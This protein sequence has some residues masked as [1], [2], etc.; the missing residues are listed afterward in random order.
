MVLVES[1]RYPRNNKKCGQN[2]FINS[3]NFLQIKIS[4]CSQIHTLYHAIPNCDLYS[5]N[6]KKVIFGLGPQCIFIRT[7]DRLEMRILYGCSVS[8]EL[9]GMF[10]VKAF[11]T[12]WWWKFSVCFFCSVNVFVVLDACWKSS[13]A[14]TSC[15]VGIGKRSTGCG[16]IIRDGLQYTEPGG[17]GL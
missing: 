10:Y 9:S 3:L 11:Q 8:W 13:L 17:T 2:H 6:E 12:K 16:F 1:S 15:V 4:I 14:A 5:R 7:D